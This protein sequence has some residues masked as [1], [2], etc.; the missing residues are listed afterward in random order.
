MLLGR[1][2]ESGKPF[3][4]VESVKAVSEIYAPVSGEV[5]QVNDTLIDTPELL[6]K[7]PQG[8]AWLVRVKIANPAELSG[9]MD[10]AAYQSYVAEKEKDASA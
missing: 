6:N 4:T 2:I 5:T 1:K 9:L 8:E 3:G 7:D 10:A